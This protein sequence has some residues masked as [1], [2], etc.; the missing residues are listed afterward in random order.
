M[1]D[2]VFLTHTQLDA[3]LREAVVTHLAKLHRVAA[4]GRS[5]ADFNRAEAARADPR[6]AWTYRLLAFIP[7]H[8]HLRTFWGGELNGGGWSK[9]WRQS[10][11]LQPQRK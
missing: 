7:L 5:A 4:A 10:T 3:M 1:P 6:A 2:P 11:R 9:R 8:A